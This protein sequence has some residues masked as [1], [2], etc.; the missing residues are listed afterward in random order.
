MLVYH[1][2]MW[3][4]QN[5]DISHSR[6]RLDF[7][8]GFYLAKEYGQAKKWAERF[9]KRRYQ[10]TVNFYQLDMAQV[11]QKFL[12]KT[13]AAYDEEWLDFIVANRKGK[14]V[15]QYDVIHGGIA[16]DRVFN[17]VELYLDGLISETDALGRLQYQKPNWQICIR[18]Q[19]IL[20]EYLH[21]QKSEVC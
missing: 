1:G 9:V 11:E 16:N 5:P 15:K 17:T 2:A 3:E 4:I 7:G 13:F 18:N 21:F 20:D 14:R 12:T 8:K 6:T 10:G 19:Q